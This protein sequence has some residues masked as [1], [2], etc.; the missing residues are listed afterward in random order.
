[1]RHQRVSGFPEKGADPW[2]GAGN[3]RGSLGN[4]WGKSTVI[5][6]FR[7][8][9]QGTSG[10]VAGSSEKSREFPEGLGDRSCEQQ[11]S[12]DVQAAMKQLLV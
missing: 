3:F 12:A 6:K 10:E 11:I 7:E 5:E 8:S 9:R 1:M 4:F 2:G